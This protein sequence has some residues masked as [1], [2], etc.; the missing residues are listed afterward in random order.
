[1]EKNFVDHFL[2]VSNNTDKKVI[3]IV[4]GQLISGEYLI[5]D[6]HDNSKEDSVLDKTLSRLNIY[7]QHD[8]RNDYDI[9]FIKNVEI[10]YNEKYSKTLEFMA[11]N[12]ENVN[13]ISI[14]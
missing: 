11:I 9:F 6:T 1:M 2:N 10:Y 7:K 14:Q 3:L 4:N 8:N 13:S 5:T 12:Y